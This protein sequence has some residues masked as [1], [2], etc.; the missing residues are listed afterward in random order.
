MPSY[1]AIL[2]GGIVIFF[3]LGG[4]DVAD[5]EGPVGM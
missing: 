4:R 1:I 3:G 5:G 2:S